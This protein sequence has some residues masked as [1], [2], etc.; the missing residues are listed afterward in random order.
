MCLNIHKNLK[1]TNI[2]KETEVQERTVPEEKVPLPTP[3]KS[4]LEKPE[5]PPTKGTCQEASPEKKC[6]LYSLFSLFIT[7]SIKFVS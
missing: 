5:L 3:K 4:Q 7:E 1:F 6:F 2:F